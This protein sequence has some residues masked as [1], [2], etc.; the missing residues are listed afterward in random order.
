MHIV[1]RVSYIYYI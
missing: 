1:Y